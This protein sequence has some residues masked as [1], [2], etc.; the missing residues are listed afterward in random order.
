ME[1]DK[2]TPT[3]PHGVSPVVRNFLIDCIKYGVV[4]ELEKPPRR[5]KYFYPLR[6][7]N[8]I[9]L[10]YGTEATTYDLAQ[11]YDVSRNRV[12]EIIKDGMVKMWEAM[13]KEVQVIYNSED[14]PKLKKGHGPRAVEKMI[15]AREGKD[16]PLRGRKIPKEQV[17]AISQKSNALWQDPDYRKKTLE[18]QR[19]YREL[20]YGKNTLRKSKEKSPRQKREAKIDVEESS[21]SAPPAR[22]LTGGIRLPEASLAN[23][24]RSLIEDKRAK[25]EPITIDSVCDHLT[26]LGV[27]FGPQQIL[28]I[29]DNL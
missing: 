18:G 4:E 5:T 16:N 20:R 3:L 9:G 7:R 19:A 28:R 26:H 8:I 23:Y 29:M 27:N 21:S 1:R 12:A 11:M 15:A 17:D 2:P 25:Q 6:N 24:V 10:Y 13:P 22:Y 14:I